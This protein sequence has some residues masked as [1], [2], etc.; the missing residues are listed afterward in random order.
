VYLKKPVLVAVENALMDRLSALLEGGASIDASLLKV[1]HQYR[2]FG[3]S[4]EKSIG[5]CLPFL[6]QSLKALAM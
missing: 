1:V 3:T 4:H 2:Y 5:E 6:E